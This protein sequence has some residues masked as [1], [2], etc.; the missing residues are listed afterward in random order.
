VKFLADMGVSR[1][2]AE[3]LRALGHEADHLREIGLQ[4]LPDAEIL[5]R[6]RRERRVVLTFDLDFADLLAA[7]GEVLPSVILF[8]LRNQTPASVTPR[9][10]EVVGRCAPDLEAGAII[11]VEE[12]RYRVRRLPIKEPGAEGEDS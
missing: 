6:V 8:R 9:L 11:T 4:R 12:S 2:T 7:S 10:L 5:D 1:S 3:R